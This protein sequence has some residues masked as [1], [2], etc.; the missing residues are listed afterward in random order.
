M[1]G[2]NPALLVFGKWLPLS[3]SQ[4]PHLSQ[5]DHWAAQRGRRVLSAGDLFIAPW[6]RSGRSAGSAGRKEVLS[7][8]WGSSEGREFS[9]RHSHRLRWG[10]LQQQ[11]QQG[12]KGGAGRAR[13]R[14]PQLLPRMWGA[15]RWRQ[16]RVCLAELRC[17]G[18]D[19]Y[20]EEV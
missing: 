9:P 18:G 4:F 17:V 12:R 6:G 1:L 15:G 2:S 5:A 16:E 11:A 10:P 7:Q 13:N 14:L 8:L 19:Q 20:T 3:K